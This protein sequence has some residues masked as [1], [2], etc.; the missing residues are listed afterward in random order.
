M[1]TTVFGMTG[2]L[3]D[4]CML[5]VGGNQGVVGM[6]KE[7]LGLAL[8]LNVPV[9]VV[10]TKIDMC[11]A[12]VLEN[13]MKTLKKILKSPAC[14]KLPLDIHDENDVVMAAH[15]FSSE[16]ICPIFKVSN[17]T[18]ENL[19]LLKSF[20]NVLTSRSSSLKNVKQVSSSVEI[21]SGRIEVLLDDCFSVAGVG[22]VLSGTVLSGTLRHNSSLMFGPDALGKF[23]PV[24]VRTLQRRRLPVEEASPGQTVAAAVRK[25][26]RKDVRKG[27]VLISKS[28]LEEYKIPNDRGLDLF[29]ACHFLPDLP[30]L[31]HPTTIS[32]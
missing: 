19:D 9:F 21:D 29:A 8:A 32:V 20:L 26:K 25:V 17:V 1:G 2:H 18:G 16:R 11:P 10:V 31:H 15:N 5:I 27:Q 7:H 3:P 6:S 12:N 22:T 28:A 4:F 30:I 13:T 23:I 24:E 14:R